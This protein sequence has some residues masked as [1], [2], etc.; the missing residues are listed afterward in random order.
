M[1]S[2]ARAATAALNSAVTICLVQQRPS[3]CWNSWINAKNSYAHRSE[4]S[5][6]GCDYEIPYGHTG[7]NG[8]EAA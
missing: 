6:R 4:K 7:I 2:N 5:N 1:P 8:K 3:F